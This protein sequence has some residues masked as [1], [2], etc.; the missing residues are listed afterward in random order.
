MFQMPVFLKDIL[1]TT[2]LPRSQVCHDSQ[3]CHGLYA[4][5]AM[6]LYNLTF[7]IIY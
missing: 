7:I 6:N 1:L 3:V 5:Y 2:S 4:H